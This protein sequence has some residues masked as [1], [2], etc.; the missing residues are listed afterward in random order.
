[1][2]A[3]EVRRVMLTACASLLSLREEHPGSAMSILP[4]RSLSFPSAHCAGAGVETREVV[5]VSAE[6][7]GGGSG[8]PKGNAKGI[9]SFEIG[10]VGGSSG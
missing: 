2:T 8:V 5:V 7:L 10:W 9:R 1:M 4:S 6:G 3:A